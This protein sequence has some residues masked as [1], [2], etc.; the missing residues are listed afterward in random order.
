MNPGSL[1]FSYRPLWILLSYWMW[2]RLVWRRMPTFHSE[3]HDLYC[4]LITEAAGFT[5]FIFYLICY[6]NW[7]IEFVW[8]VITLLHSFA[9]MTET[10]SPPETSLYISSHLSWWRKQ[11][12]A[13]KRP[14][15]VTLIY[16]D[17]GS[18]K[19]LWNVVPPAAR[20]LFCQLHCEINAL[21][22]RSN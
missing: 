11:Q 9:M 18:S 3:D 13:L 6:D 22:L 2:C 1:R 5:L 19:L 16:R 14:Y 15:T 21:Q 4:T 17:D 10:A 12:V 20:V 7:G 8:N